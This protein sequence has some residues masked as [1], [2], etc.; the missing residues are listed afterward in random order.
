MAASRNPFK[1]ANGAGLSADK[2]E[3]KGTRHARLVASGRVWAR[4]RL[5]AAGTAMLEIVPHAY[6]SLGVK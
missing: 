4:T 5:D 1:G 2:R 3:G 6:S